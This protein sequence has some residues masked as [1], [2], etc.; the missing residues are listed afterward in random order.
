MSRPLVL[1]IGGSFAGLTAAFE[2]KR[3]LTDK[4]NVCV[5]ARQEEFVLIPSLIWLVPGWRRSEQIIFNLKPSLESK[6]IEFV[7]VRVDQIIPKKN[8]VSTTSADF[9]FDYLVI[10]APYLI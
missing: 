8:K 6:N 4:V 10:A 9:S 7:L 5:I 3:R 2:L 1:V